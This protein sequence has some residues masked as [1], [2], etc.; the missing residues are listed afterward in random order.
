M[1]YG[2]VLRA[3]SALAICDAANASICKNKQI[4]VQNRR[5]K[6][7][8]GWEFK[9]A[10][11]M[12]I[13]SGGRTKHNVPEDDASAEEEEGVFRCVELDGAVAFVPSE[14]ERR[15]RKEIRT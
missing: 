7:G 14:P 3:T 2:P 10:H 5:V 9:T 11:T 8:M 12:V 1:A 6:R 15:L 4:E 13:K